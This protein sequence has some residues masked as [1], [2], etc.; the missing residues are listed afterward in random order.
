MSGDESQ[1]DRAWPIAVA[2]AIGVVLC[3]GAWKSI[4]IAMWIWVH[5]DVVVTG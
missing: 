2:A 3:L 1:Y 4:E 5:V